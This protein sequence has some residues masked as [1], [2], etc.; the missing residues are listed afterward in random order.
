MRVIGWLRVA[1]GLAGAVACALGVVATGE[2]KGRL[3]TGT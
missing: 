3:A 2:V 1:I